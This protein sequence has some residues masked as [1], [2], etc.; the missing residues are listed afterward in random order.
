MKSWFLTGSLIVLSMNAFSCP[1]LQGKYQLI[2]CDGNEPSTVLFIPLADVALNRQNDQDILMI[3]Q[4][5]CDYEF[6]YNEKNQGHFSEL[7]H[8]NWMKPHEHSQHIYKVDFS[9]RTQLVL[10]SKPA[11]NTSFADGKKI[12]IVFQKNHDG[13]LFISKKTVDK[14]FL[15]VW[16]VIDHWNAKCQLVP[17]R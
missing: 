11:P 17:I 5:G 1:K 3:K 4:K 13:E 8:S 16:P 6:N 7:K 12:K 9:D 14:W 15:G 2:S 10:N